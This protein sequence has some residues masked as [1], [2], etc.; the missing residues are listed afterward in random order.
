[1][2]LLNIEKLENAIHSQ[3]VLS[4]NFEDKQLFRA[5][6]TDYIGADDFQK[7]KRLGLVTPVDTVSECS[8]ILD[9]KGLHAFDIEA[10]KIVPI[11]KMEANRQYEIRKGRFCTTSYKR[12]KTTFN[13]VDELKD[14][15]ISQ[16]RNL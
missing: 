14:E 3:R 15:L 6:D 1:M 8:I 16:I 2:N 7:L 9:C 5:R 12:Y 10:E 13:S 11:S 4:R